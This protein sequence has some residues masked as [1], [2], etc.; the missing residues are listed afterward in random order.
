MNNFLLVSH[1]KM[2]LKSSCADFKSIQGVM[3]V[4]RLLLRRFIIAKLLVI[5]FLESDEDY[6]NF[7]INSSSD[8]KVLIS[9]MMYL[10]LSFPIFIFIILNIIL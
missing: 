10:D 8:K 3:Y 6:H 7:W 9:M 1:L 4:P 5:S 2:I